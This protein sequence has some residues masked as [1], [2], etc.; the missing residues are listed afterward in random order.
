VPVWSDL[1]ALESVCQSF[2][3]RRCVSLLL[4]C[5]LSTF[6]SNCRHGFLKSMVHQHLWNS[7]VI[8]PTT[9]VDVH[10]LCVHAGVDGIYFAFKSRQ[11]PR[12]G[13]IRYLAYRLPYSQHVISTFKRLTTTTTH[14]DLSH[15]ANQRGLNHY[16]ESVNSP[17]CRPYDSNINKQTTPISR[18]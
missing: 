13:S 10:Y 5:V 15:F 18:E 2:I 17:A 4:E 1:W 12:P 9:N 14:S 16:H 11:H 7:L 8:T 6:S 3:G